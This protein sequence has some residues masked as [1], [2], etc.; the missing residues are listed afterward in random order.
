MNKYE[1]IVKTFQP[2]KHFTL[3]IFFRHFFFFCN[4]Y[5]EYYVVESFSH[6]LS[7]LGSI[8]YQLTSLSTCVIYILLIHFK[9]HLI[10]YFSILF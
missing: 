7:H 4:I 8:K 2:F 9:L 1:N 10:N 6:K 3:H 5:Y